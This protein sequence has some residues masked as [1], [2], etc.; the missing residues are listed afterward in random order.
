MKQKILIFNHASVVGGAGIA[1]LNIVDSLDKEKYDLTVYCTANQSQIADFLESR[2]VK[3]LRA[4]SSPVCYMHYNG[5]QCSILSLR[6]YKNLYRINRDKEKITQAIEQ[7]KPDIVIVNSMTL[8]WIGAI[9]KKFGCKTLCFH[10]ESYAKG[11]F[12]FRTKILQKQLDKN[13][14][15]VA[16]ISNFDMQKTKLRTAEGIVIPDCVQIDEYGTVNKTDARMY[17]NLQQDGYYI[18]FLGG[19]SHLKGAD[20]IMKAID[21]CDDIPNLKLLMMNAKQ[22]QKKERRGI[23]AFLKSLLALDEEMLLYNTYKSMKH[24]ERIVFCDATTNT[25]VWYAAA[26]LVVFPSTK[27]HQAMPIYEAGIA[28]RLIIVSDFP[29][30]REF[31]KNEENGLTFHPSN[32]ESLAER[33]V[34]AYHNALT[35]EYQEMLLYNKKMTISNHQFI[36]FQK[37]VREFV[38]Y[39]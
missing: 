35:D 11:L 10:R 20:I 34:W 37:R 13:F 18:L 4:I 31:L 9:A 28:E 14:D 21:L 32:C 30:T 38:K 27:A 15:K 23:K 16:F 6:Y 25:P 26:D 39:V 19:S 36:D 22:P 33:I 7:E 29:N 5:G 3:V 24:P 2:G 1:L 12:G 17:N 8:Y